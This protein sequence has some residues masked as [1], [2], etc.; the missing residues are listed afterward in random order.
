MNNPAPFFFMKQPSRPPIV[1]LAL[2]VASPGT[3]NAANSVGF[4]IGPNG[5]DVAFSQGCYF[6]RNHH[7]HF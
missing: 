7:R 6:D 1:A 5:A 4:V 3:A 2:A